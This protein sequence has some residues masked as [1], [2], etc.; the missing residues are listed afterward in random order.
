MNAPV[1]LLK[2]IMI[3]LGAAAILVLAALTV[4]VRRLCRKLLADEP[5]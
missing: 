3:A 5:R 2:E 1:P 4:L